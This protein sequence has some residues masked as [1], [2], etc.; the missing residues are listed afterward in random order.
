MPDSKDPLPREAHVQVITVNYRTPALAVRSLASLVGENSSLARLSAVVVDNASGDDS[1]AVLS[2]A[3]RERGW[4][5]AE[6]K[7]L[8][9]NPPG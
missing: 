8:D 3:I 9:R 5:W 4:K 6:L 7:P 2:A 1:L